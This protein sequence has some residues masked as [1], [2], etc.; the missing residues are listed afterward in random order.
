MGMPS[1]SGYYTEN[2]KNFLEE[3]YLGCEMQRKQGLLPNLLKYTKI[4]LKLFEM[5]SVA[6][7]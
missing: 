4:R 6:I 1:F 5:A 7:H 3:D 2:L